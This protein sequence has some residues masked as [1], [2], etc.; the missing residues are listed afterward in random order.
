MRYKNKYAVN[1]NTYDVCPL[2]L[3]KMKTINTLAKYSLGTIP[4]MVLVERLWN[5]GGFLLNAKRGKLNAN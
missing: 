1:H 2:T 4:T 3:I 5:S